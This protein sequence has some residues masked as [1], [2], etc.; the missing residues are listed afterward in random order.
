MD[1]ISEYLTVD[2]A[3]E[4]TGHSKSRIRWWCREKVIYGALKEKGR[5]GIPFA[6][7]FPVLG[8]P[9]HAE[10]RAEVGRL[11][12]EF[13]LHQ[14]SYACHLLTQVAGYNKLVLEFV[15]E[16]KSDIDARLLV[17]D[18]W[19]FS[20]CHIERLSSEYNRDGLRGLIEYEQALA[21]VKGLP[22]ISEPVLAQ[23]GYE[24]AARN[25]SNH[26]QPISIRWFIEILGELD[27]VGIECMRKNLEGIKEGRQAVESNPNRRI[28][29]VLKPTRAENLERIEYVLSALEPFMLNEVLASVKIALTYVEHDEDGEGTTSH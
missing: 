16:G 3:V 14:I 5:W 13:S 6:G 27:D 9:E 2:E 17:C 19:D 23:K 8:K 12:S 18:R 26:N 21:R 28:Y 11:R 10:A 7:I 20:L 22:A 25:K 1:S 15:G 24:G 29:A 4:V